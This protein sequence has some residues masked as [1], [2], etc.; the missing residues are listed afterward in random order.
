[1]ELIKSYGVTTEL[2]G[3]FTGHEFLSFQALSQWLYTVGIARC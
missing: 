1:M 2:F 3:F